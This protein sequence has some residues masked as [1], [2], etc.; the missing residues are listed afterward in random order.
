M[1]FA[2]A[3]LEHLR[4][5]AYASLGREALQEQ[6]AAL[7]RQKAEI[8]DT[9]PPFGLLARKETRDAF[10]RSMRTALD[11]E[12]ALRERL[13]RLDGILDWLRPLIRN[14]VSAY[15]AGMSQP[16][17]ALLQ[18]EARLDDWECAVQALSD[19]LLAFA[20]DVH[21]VRVAAS[22]AGAAPPAYARELAAL[23]TI[24]GRLERHRHELDVIAQAIGELTAG[25]LPTEVRLPALPDFRR[26]AWLDRLALLS[27]A[28][29]VAEAT[30]VEAEA[31]SFLADENLAAGVAARLQAN[32][33]LCAN[34]AEN[35][36]EQYW[37][38]LRTHACAHY[39]EERDVD[40]VLDMLTRRY[41]DADI[42]SRLD[43]PFAVAN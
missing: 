28:Q 4:D 18:V 26:S 23:R 37:N 27:P 31:R 39:V 7:E 8:A 11:N 13:A 20:R 5:E 19:L 22:P 1:E 25:G 3:T 42:Q 2:S 40:E 34:L 35:A 33:D 43:E 16:Y 24:V 15:L 41:V 14:G 32:R 29:V 6:L 17:C 30:R 21:S 10:T 12:V 36:L 38:Q 9:R